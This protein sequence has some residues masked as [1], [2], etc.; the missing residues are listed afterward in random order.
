MRRGA[1]RAAVG[2]G[3]VAA[4]AGGC[5]GIPSAGTAQSTPAPPALAGE[6]P[7]PGSVPI[8]NPPNASMDPATVVEAFLTASAYFENDYALA[9]RY[10]TASAS[11][12][13][14]PGSAV[15][16]LE[17]YPNV[18]SG[19]LGVTGQ[20]GAVTDV[21][22]GQKIA[23]LKAT[24]RYVPAAQ[25]EPAKEDFTLQLVHGRYLIAGLPSGDP[26][27]PSH[28]L[29][30]TSYLFDHVYTPRDLYYYSGRDGTLVPEPVF[31]L[32]QSA[33]Q[34]MKLISD[35]RRPPTGMLAQAARTAFPAGT[36]LVRF[37]AVPGPS[38]GKIAI[39]GLRLPAPARYPQQ[40]EV[41]AQVVA[42]LTSPA[43]N[44]PA[45]FRAVRLRINGR[46]LYPP[47]SNNPLLGPASLPHRAPHLQARAAV[48]YLTPG[49]SPRML[50]SSAQQGVPLAGGP[51]G[52]SQLAVAPSRRYLAG[53]GPPG[54]TVYTS[55]HA[56]AEPDAG[57]HPAG[58]HMRAQLTGRG[59]AGLSW[60]SHDN[61][62][63]AGRLRG[64]FGLWVLPGG[65]GPGERVRLPAGV[66]PVTGVRVAPDGVR[67]AMIAG[68]GAAAH[69]VLGAIEPDGRGFAIAGAVPLGQ[70]MPPVIAATWY[71]E[72]Y[73]LAVTRLRTKQ[74][75]QSGLYEVP[76][77]GDGAGGALSVQSG[78]LTITADGPLSPLYLGLSH[79]RLEKAV[80]LHE[81]WSDI[82]AG[83]A[84]AY[85][86]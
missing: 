72:D 11:R 63:V 43:Y 27:H 64:A 49:G 39:V 24:G 50:G 61:L 40:Q 37:Q 31:L 20:G 54:T 32:S 25:G 5:A 68:A 30:L 76:A 56:G 79:Q 45:L 77:N 62:W 4:L 36:R 10:L 26:Q 58:L 14:R 74:G 41:A 17:T 3:L 83:I 86:G 81:Q 67:I 23:S 42:T 7:A 15:T 1:V 47:R 6:A 71:G 33:G 48:Y 51:A 73:L 44:S 82:T 78:M 80:R 13:W 59:L 35:L 66:G 2:A 9:R 60:D 53:L 34:G 69:L 18:T 28:E 55:A 85:P 19:R 46:L 8:L 22:T 70:G 65:R 12:S 16:I 84:P 52:L 38:G 21:V 57:S 29:V 75:V